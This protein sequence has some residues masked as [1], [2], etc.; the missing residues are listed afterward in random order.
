MTVRQKVGVGLLAGG[1]I[2]LVLGSFGVI[3]KAVPGI[4]SQIIDWVIKVLPLFGFAVVYPNEQK[5]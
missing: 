3:D 2:G 5:G 4:V 1:V